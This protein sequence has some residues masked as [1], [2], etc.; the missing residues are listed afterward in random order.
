MDERILRA[1]DEG[2]LESLYVI[3]FSPNILEQRGN[4]FPDPAGVQQEADSL[5]RN[6]LNLIQ[7]S[8]GHQDV[9]KEELGTLKQA[10]SF[11]DWAAM[12]LRVTLQV[13]QSF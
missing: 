8:E 2:E 11:S 7:A 5:G 9:P 4:E 1:K 6:A 12:W 3:T 10:P 13:F